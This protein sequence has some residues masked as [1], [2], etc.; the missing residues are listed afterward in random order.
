M[1]KSTNAHAAKNSVEA[2][3]GAAI[4]RIRK[5][6]STPFIVYSVTR[7]TVSLSNPILKHMV[8]Y[9][10][11]QQHHHQCHVMTLGIQVHLLIYW[12]EHVQ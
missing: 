5:I 11:Y 8:G 7:V 6:A 2:Q 10:R 3:V 12:F 4:Q 1:S 9:A